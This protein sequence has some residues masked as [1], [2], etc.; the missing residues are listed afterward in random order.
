[1]IKQQWAAELRILIHPYKPHI[2]LLEMAR[3]RFLHWF[4]T[5]FMQQLLQ[6]E[7]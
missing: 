2:Q 7:Q 6:I 3:E 5:Q 1:M 4:I